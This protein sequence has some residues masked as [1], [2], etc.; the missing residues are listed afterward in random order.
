MSI[1]P[2]ENAGLGQA[3]FRFVGAVEKRGPFIWQENGIT[4][5]V[6]APGQPM[7]TCA[8]CG[9]G[10]A[11][12]CQIESADGK[13]FEVGSDCVRKTGDARVS[14]DTERALR[15]MTK[16]REGERADAMRE[17]LS[18]D[19]ALREHLASLPSPTRPDRD[20]ALGWADWMMR[21][22]GHSGRMRTTRWLEAH[23]PP[24][25]VPA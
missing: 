25:A 16:A 8:Y 4:H 15:E 17:R 5:M 24:A 3:P 14:T 2:F 12:C 1:H 23:L 19:T 22:S 10:I 20:T 11:I 21:N 7:G 6:G 9:Q 18:T 13:R